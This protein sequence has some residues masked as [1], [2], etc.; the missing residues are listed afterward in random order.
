MPGYFTRFVRDLKCMRSLRT[1]RFVDL[2]IDAEL[3]LKSLLKG[4]R[5]P[6]RSPTRLPRPRDVAAACLTLR[7]RRAAPVRPG[8]RARRDAGRRDRCRPAAPRAATA[9]P[10]LSPAKQRDSGRRPCGAGHLRELPP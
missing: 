8:P 10:L 3:D 6:R 9:A 2:A 4:S 1:D 5:P 7:D